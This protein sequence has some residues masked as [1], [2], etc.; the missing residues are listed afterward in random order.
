MSF[1]KRELERLEGLR[2]DGRRPLSKLGRLR[3]ATAL[4]AFSYRDDSDAVKRAYAIGTNM[5]KAGEVD[6]TREE[7]MDAIKDAIENSYNDCPYCA[8][9]FG[10]ESLPRVLGEERR[11]VFRLASISCPPASGEEVDER[12][13]TAARTRQRKRSARKAARRERRSMTPERR[14]EI[15]QKASQER[16]KKEQ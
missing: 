15:A 13:P 14:V 5:M 11:A 1:A 10:D 12:A 6:S 16:W 2:T 8:K 4:K 9:A 3:H 7:L